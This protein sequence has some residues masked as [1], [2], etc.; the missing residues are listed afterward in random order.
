MTFWPE[1]D[2]LLAVNKAEYLCVVE[3]WSLGRSV[4]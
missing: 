2:T 4:V 1:T 3:E